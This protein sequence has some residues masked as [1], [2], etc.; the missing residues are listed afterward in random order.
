[1]LGDLGYEGEREALT[2]AARYTDTKVRDIA[3]TL[4]RTGELPQ[5]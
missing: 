1:M 3:D 5:L 4:V 2:R